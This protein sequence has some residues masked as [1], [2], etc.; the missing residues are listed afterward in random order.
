MRTRISKGVILAVSGLMLL[1]SCGRRDNY[2]PNESDQEND[3]TSY[4]ESADNSEAFGDETHFESSIDTNWETNPN[5]HINHTGEK[6][7]GNPYDGMTAAELYASFQEENERSVYNNINRFYCN[8]PYYVILDSQY[9]GCMFSKLT[10]QVMRICK[11]ALCQHETCIFNN[12]CFLRSTQVVDDRIYLLIQDA[13]QLKYRLFSFNLMLDDAKMICEWDTEPKSL[14]IYQNK[15]YYFVPVKNN[16]LYGYSAMVADL[17][18]G[19]GRLLWDEAFLCRMQSFN[20]EYLWYTSLDNGALYRYNLNTAIHEQVLSHEMLNVE[21]GELYYSFHAYANNTLYYRIA[22][23]DYSM[24][25]QQ[26]NLT[27][28]EIQSWD[29]SHIYDGYHYFVVDHSTDEYIQD[30]H[31]EY[32][33]TDNSFGGELYRV[34]QDMETKELVV[35]LTTDSIPDQFSQYKYGYLFMDK[36]FVLIC[37]QTY[38][39]YPNIYNA[40]CPTWAFSLKYV[41]A[42]L[43]SGEVYDLGID[44]SHQSINN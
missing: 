37:Y 1:S 20:G 2:R 17:N 44:L 34:G 35:K 16:D 32:Y 29:N 18:D 22:Y 28:R 11:D 12:N 43:E 8:T 31:Y 33:C 3:S 40:N 19:I 36:K 10:G 41:I 6:K 42:N 15:M 39:D 9:G 24:K 14:Y 21:Q 38:K 13:I 4:Y 5:D 7:E 26:M 23:A 25:Y 30:Q 27:S